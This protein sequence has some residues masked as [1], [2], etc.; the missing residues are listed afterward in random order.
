MTDDH[1]PLQSGILEAIGHQRR[2][3]LQGLSQLNPAAAVFVALW[4]ENVPTRREQRQ[5]DVVRWLVAAVEELRD[6]ID[7]ARLRSDAFADLFENVMENVASAKAGDKRRFY[8]DVLAKA[9]VIDAPEWDRQERMVATLDALRPSHL[10]VLALMVRDLEKQERFSRSLNGSRAHHVMLR[11]EEH[12]LDLDLVNRD[13]EDMVRLG[14]LEPLDSSKADSIRRIAGAHVQ[15]NDDEGSVS[16]YLDTDLSDFGWQ[17]A[18]S[19]SMPER[20]GA[21]DEP[22]NL[23]D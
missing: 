18:E 12:A 9:L 6:R 10:R 19:L 20:G 8:A 4:S 22:G 7:Q 5:A 1:P 2:A 15:L 21:E 16:I 17:F 3:M 13:C 23:R 11:L 14:I